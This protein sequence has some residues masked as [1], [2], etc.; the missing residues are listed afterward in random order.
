MSPNPRTA[1]R[2]QLPLLPPCQ[3]ASGER[4]PSARRPLSVLIVD[5]HSVVRCGL[6]QILKE[7]C[8]EVTF[9]EAGTA[10]EALRQ[11]SKRAW[12]LVILALRIAGE[13]TFDT[14]CEIRRQHT[15]MKVLMFSMYRDPRYAA[16]AL[17]L[18]A[19]GYLSKDA[20]RTQL[21]QAVQNVLAGEQHVSPAMRP[22]LAAL[23]AL[24]ERPGPKA[25]SRREEQV[26]R[27]LASGMLVGQI[28]AHLGLSVKTV[29]TYK[30]RI[31]DKLGLN[32]TADLVRYYIDQR[33]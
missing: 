7:A 31:L 20:S 32:S 14:L 10:T 23:Q 2:Q 6:K 16:R 30:R 29:S 5:D 17:Q 9:G 4:S 27:A 33:L 25:L 22:K 3:D 21:M 13:E 26:E 28:A 15:E 24:A 8:H 1:D 11:A 12:D 19:S 18:G